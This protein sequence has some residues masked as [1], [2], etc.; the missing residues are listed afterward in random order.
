MGVGVREKRV[1]LS[2]GRR[3]GWGEGFLRSGCI[4]DYSTLI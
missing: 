1:K 3:E 2:P 4:S